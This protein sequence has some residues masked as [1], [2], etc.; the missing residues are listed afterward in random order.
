M[1]QLVETVPKGR[2]YRITFGFSLT[3]GG[4]A[5]P[6]GTFRCFFSGSASP[7]PGNKLNFNFSG[8]SGEPLAPYA[9]LNTQKRRPEKTHDGMRLRSTLYGWRGGRPSTR[10]FKVKFVARWMYLRVRGARGGPATSVMFL[11]LLAGACGYTTLFRGKGVA[12]APKS[13]KVKFVARW[14]YFKVR[15]RVHCPLRKGF[16]QGV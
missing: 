1:R 10:I 7:Q 13:L 8:R 14:M 6:V 16:M 9:K 5:A 15:G 2:G 4:C 12:G 11:C 3:S